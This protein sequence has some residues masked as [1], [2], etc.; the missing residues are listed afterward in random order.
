[1]DDAKT[2]VNT[3]DY[4]FVTDIYAL[5]TK[6]NHARKRTLSGAESV[7]GEAPFY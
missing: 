4:P 3:N 5:Q 1:M 7:L 2:S 6:M